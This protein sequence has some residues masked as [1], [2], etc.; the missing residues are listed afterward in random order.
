MSDGGRSVIQNDLALEDGCDVCIRFKTKTTITLGTFL[1]RR[2]RLPYF[3]LEQT[4]KLNVFTPKRWRPF[5]HYFFIALQHKLMVFLKVS[6]LRMEEES[7]TESLLNCPRVLRRV[8]ML[9]VELC[10]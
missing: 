3:L 5:Y 4:V 6:G 8:T 2:I 7:C 9:I 10:F 1:S